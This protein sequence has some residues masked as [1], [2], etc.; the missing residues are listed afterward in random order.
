M[1]AKEPIKSH[2]NSTRFLIGWFLED[3]SDA[4]LLKRPVPTANHIAWQ[5]DHVLASEAKMIQ[6]QLPDAKYPPLPAGFAEKHAN[7]MA[8]TDS[9]FSTKQEYLKLFNSVRDATIA[10]LEQMPDADLDKATTGQMAQ[11]APRLVDF[12]T[13]V[14]NHT[15]MHAGQFTV[16]RR[17]LGKPVLF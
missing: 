2:L 17:A 5:F 3:L 15:M 16:V 11:F 12:F 14:G 13:L 7:D 4:D 1:N 8:S 9:G 6:G 10:A